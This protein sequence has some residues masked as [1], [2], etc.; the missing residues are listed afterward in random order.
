[1]IIRKIKYNF[2]IVKSILNTDK[3]KA[4]YV[5][6]VLAAIFNSYNIDTN[7]TYLESNLGVIYTT[8]YQLFLM[9]VLFI[10]SLQ[11]TSNY[12][13]LGQNILRF[14]NK[15]EYLKNLSSTISIVNFVIF[16]CYILLT[17]IFVTIRYFGNVSLIGQLP[18]HIPYLIYIIYSFVKVFLILNILVLISSVVYICFGKKAGII[19]ITGITIFKDLVTY[20]SKI[21]KSYKDFNAFYGFFLFPYQYSNFMLELSM[22]LLEL[23]ILISL[24]LIIDKIY[25]NKFKIEIED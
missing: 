22:F 1:M 12:N 25:Q 11:T 8:M 2:N 6:C 9:I 7:N 16:V 20:N 23:I 24:Y 13:K 17:T 10:G 5:I 4:V 15:K 21:I 19:L 3:F 14:K 18:N